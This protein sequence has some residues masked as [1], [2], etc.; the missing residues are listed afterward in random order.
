MIDV[1]GLSHTAILL[2]SRHLT[3]QA[4]CELA[5]V[6]KSIWQEQFR[7]QQTVCVAFMLVSY[8]RRQVAACL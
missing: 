1:Q 6:T 7:S 4:G 3:L 5:A 8:D 2:L